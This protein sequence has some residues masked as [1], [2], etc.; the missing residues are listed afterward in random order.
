MGPLG[1]PEV[2]VILVMVL[3]YVIIA[4]L[5]LSIALRILVSLADTFG[6]PEALGRFGATLVTS[7]REHR[8]PSE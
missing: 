4:P 5:L 3:S 8:T 6:L 7:F 2:L 1:F